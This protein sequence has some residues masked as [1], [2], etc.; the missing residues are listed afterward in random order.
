MSLRSIPSTIHSRYVVVVTTFADL[1]V[2]AYRILSWSIIGHLYRSEGGALV[3]G[4]RAAKTEMQRRK[5][6]DVRKIWNNTSNGKET[7]PRFW[8][9]EKGFCALR[10]NILILTD[11]LVGC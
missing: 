6:S 11:F 10:P 7:G 2:P 9:Q 4:S 1:T 8:D 5:K 3:S